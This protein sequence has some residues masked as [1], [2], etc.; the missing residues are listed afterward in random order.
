MPT[1]LILELQHHL[2]ISR[3]I[4]GAA[5]RITSEIELLFPQPNV[6]I[7][8]LSADFIH[9]GPGVGEEQVDVLTVF[10]LHQVIRE[11]R[12]TCEVWND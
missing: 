6:L 11:P 4:A 5:L 8:V 1:L 2:V 3:I 12:Y 10:L 7:E 9:M